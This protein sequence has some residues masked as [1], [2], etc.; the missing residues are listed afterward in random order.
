MKRGEILARD[1]SAPEIVRAWADQRKFD[2]AS[3]PKIAEA[4]ACACADAMK[5]WRK[6]NRG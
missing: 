6:V 5:K 2:N 3:D 4:Y 1:E